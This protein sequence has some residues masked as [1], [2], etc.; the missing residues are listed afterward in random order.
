VKKWVGLRI[1]LGFLHRLWRY[2]R[3]R[4]IITLIYG[5]CIFLIMIQPYR[6]NVFVNW[7][8]TYHLLM[9]NEESFNRP[10][11]G[12]LFFAAVY[13]RAL[14]LPE[15]QCLYLQDCD[16][17]DLSGRILK[18]AI[19]LYDFSGNAGD[20]IHDGSSCDGQLDLIARDVRRTEDGRGLAFDGDGFLRSLSPA[21]KL[22]HALVKPSEMT[23]E[24]WLRTYDT[25][26]K[27]PAR[28]VTMS[29]S[30]DMRNFTLGQDGTD[31]V[32]RVRTPLTGLNGSDVELR[33]PSI[34]E[35]GAVH[36]VAAIFNH[37]VER[38][39]MD[40]MMRREVIR[41]DMDFLS[42]LVGMGRNTAAR[43]A[44][45]LTLLF[46]LGFFLNSLFTKCRFT[47]SVIGVGL[48]VLLIEVFYYRFA[49]QSFGFFI[50]WI[51]LLSGS[52]GGFTNMVLS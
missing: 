18:G 52:L 15:I 7:D 47:F 8:D 36:H 39:V 23:V 13:N 4:F 31:I 6:R 19:V 32:F 45:M 12:E 44:F 42:D 21:S 28:I 25:M 26:Q 40:G 20:T 29:E 33:V 17:F 5:I 22:V 49:G 11:K 51:T 43:L 34:L 50:L 2:F 10:W 3:V 41:G 48:F 16:G 37:G 9:G 1:S 30:V 24:V 38:M 27:G 46:P 35:E 14:M